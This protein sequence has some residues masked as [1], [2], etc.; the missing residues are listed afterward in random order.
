MALGMTASFFP[1]EDELELVAQIYDRAGSPRPDVIKGETAAEIFAASVDLEPITL[2]TIWEIAD[3]EK[4][5]YLSERG[6]AVAL[7]LIGW[8]QSGEEVC[9][10][11]VN[12]RGP[13]PRIEGLVPGVKRK[14]S[15]SAVATSKLPPFTERDRDAFQ[16]L[17]QQCGPK[18]GLLEGT[19]DSIP[20]TT[21]IRIYEEIVATF[22]SHDLASSS[23]SSSPFD[24]STTVRNGFSPPN[25]ALSTK[26]DRPTRSPPP[27]PLKFSNSP[28]EADSPPPTAVF[29][30]IDSD[31]PPSPLPSSPRKAMSIGRS[32]SARVT[33]AP[34]SPEKPPWSPQGPS[35]TLE[36]DVNPIEKATADQLFNSLDLQ[37]TGYVDGEVAAN[38]MLGYEV[39]PEDL[40]HIWYISSKLLDIQSAYALSRVLADIHGDN[41][42]TRDGFAIAM[43]LIQQRL[44]GAEL[45]HVLPSS[46]IPP[47][48]RTQSPYTPL[49]RVASVT[50]PS[51]K[52]LVDVRRRTSGPPLP[53]KPTSP[54]LSNPHPPASPTNFRTNGAHYPEQPNGTTHTPERPT[55]FSQKP[56]APR[57]SNVHSPTTSTNTTDHTPEPT[58]S[59][60]QYRNL[61]RANLL[62]ASQIEDLTAQI[63][64]NRDVRA[65]NITLTRENKALL[66]KI[67]DMEQI[68]SQLLQAN[69]TRP[70]M[71]DLARQNQELTDRNAEL[72][73]VRSQLENTAM[74]LD[75]AVLRN[76][77]L[78]GR[79]RDVRI[80]AE[81]AAE[82]SQEQVDA[83]QREVE[84]LGGENTDL[85]RRAGELERAITQ[86]Q[87]SDGT[88]NV[89]ELEILMGDVTR[90]NEGLKQR[91]RQ[92]QRSTTHLLLSTGS[93]HA[94]HDDLRR[95]NQRLATQVE[96]LEG[97]T[98]QLQQS[99]EDSELQR[100][101]RDVTHEND[102]LK[103]ELREMR[104]QM[105]QLRSLRGEPSER[106]INDL[107]AEIQRLQTELSRATPQSQEDRSIPPPAYDFDPS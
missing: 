2:S 57:L 13:L 25:A 48:M 58:V 11:L 46:L 17:F 34:A 8:A 27:T 68:T 26:P 21:P 49:Q 28:A 14:P 24:T 103:A 106:E 104:Q 22:E 87:P 88:T 100:V 70:A 102:S 71:D 43:H 62:L 81:A 45:P 50:T 93:G 18:Y 1:S 76:R 55:P 56:T 107:K 37:K 91:L 5:G 105:T 41:R 63:D 54:R 35:H 82:R 99:S 95:E 65:A 72:E 92:I 78:S 64:A 85:R 42:L 69:E 9:A 7:R 73:Q 38:F 44:N 31:N 97:L 20:S 10:G 39:Q 30:K 53:P 19:L 101:L 61:E 23:P 77:A 89:R 6:V 33:K 83:L 32:C 74:R 16:D 51:R 90:E 96:E 79:L 3:K 66:A 94:A 52:A 86:A 4:A 84:R 67:H 47:S 98:R 36:W 12:I 80:A 75:T 29:T 40:S 59:S 15:V 60:E